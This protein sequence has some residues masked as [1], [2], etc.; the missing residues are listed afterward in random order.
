[1]LT[2]PAAIQIQEN[3]LRRA[4]LYADASAVI[5]DRKTGAV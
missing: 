2:L 5:T 4:E 1:M 3:D